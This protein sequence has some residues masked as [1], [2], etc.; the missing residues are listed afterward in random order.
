MHKIAIIKITETNRYDTEGVNRDSKIIESITEWTEVSNEE[1]AALRHFESLR[2]Y[3]NDKFILLEQPTNVKEFV[4]NTVSSYVKA[5][6]EAKKKADIVAAKAKKE[7]ADRAVKAKEKAE[8]KERD[9][10]KKL[11]VKHGS[12]IGLT[13]PMVEASDKST[14]A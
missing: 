6:Q 1:M 7:A 12:S 11:L 14:K 13:A 10:L 2:R 9:Q 5:A 3:T 4:A 8:A